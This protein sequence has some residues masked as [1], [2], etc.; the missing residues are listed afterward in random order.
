MLI[1]A[2]PGSLQSYRYAQ[3]HFLFPSVDSFGTLLLCM[4]VPSLRECLDL[5][6]GDADGEV[7]AET[8]AANTAKLYDT[9]DLFLRTATLGQFHTRLELVR[10]FAVQL[11]LQHRREK[12]Q[13]E[14]AHAAGAGTDDEKRSV[15]VDVDVDMHDGDA[16][17]RAPGSVDSLPP[18]SSTAASTSVGASASVASLHASALHGLWRY[19]EQV[20]LLHDDA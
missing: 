3:E 20:K 9:L 16:D 14:R 10:T 4:R 1:R 19:Y 11:T 7:D 15:D 5:S 8:T 17:G 18:S 2:S 6:Q 13:H 12:Q